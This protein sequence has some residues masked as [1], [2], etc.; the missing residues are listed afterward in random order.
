MYSR[1]KSNYCGKLEDN[2]DTENNRQLWSGINRITNYKPKA[3]PIDTSDTTL[4][5]KLNAFSGRFDDPS[6]AVPIS[7]P[8]VQD[9]ND[10][11]FSISDADLKRELA[12]LHMR[13]SPGPDK[14]SPRLL[15][16]CCDQLSSVIAHIF[17]WSLKACH[18]PACFKDA[19]VVPV[20]KKR[21]SAAST[22]TVL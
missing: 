14:I 22:I 4:P 5:D 20:P 3:T 8:S 21:R 1:T 6:L 2:L 18:V 16:Q 19:I 17:N 9:I 15:R 7:P 13:K 11:Q 10:V 12:R